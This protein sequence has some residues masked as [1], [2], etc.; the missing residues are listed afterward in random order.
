MLAISSFID[1]ENLAVRMF[2]TFCIAVAMVSAGLNHWRDDRSA[3]LDT[4]RREVVV[5]RGRDTLVSIAFDDVD[6]I[7]L[8]L[9]AVSAHDKELR[10][11]V[12]IG[13]AAMPIATGAPLEKLRALA[14]EI[15]EVVGYEGEI[16]V[17]VA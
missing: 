8:E 14:S 12:T 15:A 2:G 13:A 7:H 1:S 4:E 3:T 11:I 6:A 5:K 10:L 16:D 17:R 9:T